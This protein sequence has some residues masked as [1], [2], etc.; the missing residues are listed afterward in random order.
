METKNLIQWRQRTWLKENEEM[1]TAMEEKNFSKE[2]GMKDD[3]ESVVRRMNPLLWTSCLGLRMSRVIF[4]KQK[5]EQCL[6]QPDLF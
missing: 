4:I 2:D 6:K 1:F 5:G 3:S